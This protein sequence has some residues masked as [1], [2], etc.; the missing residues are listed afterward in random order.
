MANMKQ[1]SLL[2]HLTPN[3]RQ[4]FCFTHYAPLLPLYTPFPHRFRLLARLAR[5]GVVAG[6]AALPALGSIA[7]VTVWGWWVRR[8]SGGAGQF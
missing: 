1:R 6:P 4:H 2:S 5:L 7:I 3:S 8:R